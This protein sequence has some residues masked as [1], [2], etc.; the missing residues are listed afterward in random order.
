MSKLKYD[1]EIPI[2]L[3]FESE[4]KFSMD[5]KVFIDE[6]IYKNITIT[7]FRKNNYIPYNYTYN[8]YFKR[9]FENFDNCSYLQFTIDKKQKCLNLDY[10]ISHIGCGFMIDILFNIIKDNYPI[11]I[12][13]VTLSNESGMKE[14]VSGTICFLKYIGKYYPIL[15]YNSGKSKTRLDKF[16]DRSDWLNILKELD[17]DIIWDYTDM[18]KFSKEHTI[19]KK[20]RNKKSRNKKSRNK[21]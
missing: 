19:S 3:R 6:T 10:I 15:S 4:F 13:S 1:T 14:S 18:Y 8:L 12:E 16:Y 2:K 11:E 17:I 21:K 5:D 7:L 20:S 9:D